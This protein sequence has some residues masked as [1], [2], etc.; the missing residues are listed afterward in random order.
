MKTLKRKE[1][2][3]IWVW[4]SSHH[5]EDAIRGESLLLNS[6]S[7]LKTGKGVDVAA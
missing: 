3:N 4:F 6:L 2:P 7:W 5:T 1:K